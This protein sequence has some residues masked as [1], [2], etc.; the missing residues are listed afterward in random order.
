VDPVT[1]PVSIASMEHPS[2]PKK[3]TRPR[4]T[5]PAA[6]AVAAPAWLVHLAPD[7]GPASVPPI[8]LTNP[9]VTFGTDPVQ[10]TFIL[11]EPVLSPLHARIQQSEAGYVIFDLGSVGGTWVNYE[12]VT[13]EGHP[14][15]HG[16]RVHFGYLVFRFE[17][18]NPPSIP[19]L[20]ITPTDS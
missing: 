8:A 19:E 3:T 15:N 5:K 7:G 1:Q 14:L 9:D 18:K 17:L 11:D 12:P 2:Q 20:T 4:R 16:D 6:K 10:S 13:R